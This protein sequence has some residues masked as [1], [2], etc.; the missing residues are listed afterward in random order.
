MNEQLMQEV[1]SNEEFVMSLLELETGEEVQKALA[2]KGL[3]F[4]LEEI[5]LIKE[6]LANPDAGEE[7]SDDDLE[8]VAGGSVTLA[9]VGAVVG[10]VS[11]VVSLASAV[12]KWTRRRW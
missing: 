2:D 3:E 5:S 4:S 6:K 7:L 9:T 12:H 11:G 10:I 1:L 8:N